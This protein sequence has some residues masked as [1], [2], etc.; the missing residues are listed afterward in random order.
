MH[1]EETHTEPDRTTGL[2]LGARSS[3][4]A[5]A[6]WRFRLFQEWF[7]PRHDAPLDQF[8]GR[9]VRPPGG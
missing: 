8:V 9:P 4:D 7:V 2:D 1:D 6:E 5:A 3:D